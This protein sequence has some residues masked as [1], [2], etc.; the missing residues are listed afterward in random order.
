M[1][2]WI[3][4]CGL[5]SADAVAAAIECNVDAVGFV[6]AP[7]KRQVDPLRAAQLS[8]AVPSRIAKVAVMLHPSQ[9]ELDAVLA[10]FRPD[11]LQT[12]AVDFATLIVPSEIQ[13]LPVVRGAA[14]VAAP[15]V[16]FEGAVSGQGKIADWT[17]AA[18]L[19]RHT[20]LVLAG[21]LNPGN[22]EQAIAAVHPFGVDVSS[23]VES[24]PGRK[25]PDKIREFVQ[26]ARDL[27]C[28]TSEDR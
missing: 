27:Q 16:L 2:V 3:K 7:S 22:V 4:I 15:R 18:S 1:S 6:F 28:I 21:G 12:D 5:T 24:A 26:R 14:K 23:G 8:Q 20:Q 17:A 11:V 9:Q 25:D 19:A 13:K 10:G